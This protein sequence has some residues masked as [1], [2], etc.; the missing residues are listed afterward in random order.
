[1]IVDSLAGE[2]GA[3]RFGIQYVIRT[4]VVVRTSSSPPPSATPTTNN[5][6]KKAGQPQPQAQKKTPAFH[7]QPL[8]QNWQEFTLYRIAPQPG[9]LTVTIALTGLGECWLDDVT[10]ERMIRATGGPARMSPTASSSVLPLPAV[11]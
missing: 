3:Q 5:L 1:M 9:Q 2:P 10:V 4:P 11:R 8:N 6:K 7:V